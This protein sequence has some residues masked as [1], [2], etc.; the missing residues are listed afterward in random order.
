M[1][2][3][4]ETAV[5]RIQAL[6]AQMGLDTLIDGEAGPQ[7]LRALDA[8]AS[9]LPEPVED[10]PELM[11]G[12]RGSIAWVHAREGHNGRPYWPGGASGVTLDPGVD[13]GHQTYADVVEWYGHD[14]ASRLSH[15]LG[16]RGVAARRLLPINGVTVRRKH[17]ERLLPVVAQSYWASTV[18]RWPQL[19][20]APSLAQ[21]AMLSL[22]YNR[23][24]N[25]RHLEGLTP[26]IAE[27]AWDKAGSMVARMQQDRR[28]GIPA[29]RRAE[30]AL[31][32]MAAW[33]HA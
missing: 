26:L 23:G 22:A 28:D 15:A 32:K 21:T 4:T 25:N 33:S 5:R 13:L 31:L 16:V 8:V 24:A 30:A 2:N 29:R 20:H 7:T 9:A 3:A 6:G 12:F 17:A 18:H 14:V 10:H 11:P 19:F 1:T 27:G